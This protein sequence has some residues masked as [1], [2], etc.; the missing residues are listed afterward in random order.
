[1]ANELKKLSDKELMDWYYLA[2]EMQDGRYIKK[3]KQ[4]MSRRNAE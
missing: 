2:M 3:L 4:E 1:M